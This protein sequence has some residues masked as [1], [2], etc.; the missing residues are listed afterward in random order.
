[1]RRLL[2]L[3][4][5]RWG[6]KL[7]YVVAAYVIGTMPAQL[8]LALGAY[9]LGFVIG[10]LV[11]VGLFL[12]AARIFRGRG[13]AVEPA[14]P[15]WQMTARPTLSRRLGILFAILLALDLLGSALAAAGLYDSGALPLVVSIVSVVETGLIAFLYLNSAVRL[16]RAGVGSTEPVRPTFKPKRLKVD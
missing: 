7:V 2:D 4:I 8:G 6:W 15:W 10:A 3:R 12:Y 14:R 16:R 11:R 9:E 1:M 13:E 5:P